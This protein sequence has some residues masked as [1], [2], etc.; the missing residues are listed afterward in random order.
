MD[1]FGPDIYAVAMTPSSGASGR[2]TMTT[3]E[4]ALLTEEA[5]SDTVPA[6]RSALSHVA[7]ATGDAQ[8][9]S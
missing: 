8:R 4:D 2:G 5:E 1:R 7:R 6:P 9:A 3:P